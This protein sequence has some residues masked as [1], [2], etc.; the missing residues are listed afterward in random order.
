MNHF[1]AN[2]GNKLVTEHAQTSPLWNGSSSLYVFH[3]QIIHDLNVFN[4]LL[5]LLTHSNIHILNFDSKLLIIS[6]P[7][8]YTILICLFNASIL[9]SYVPRDWKRA[10]MTP[11]YKG[12]GSR[13]DPSNY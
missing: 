5:N 7:V 10:R 6:A 9:Q 1:F 13:S 2:V 4:H 3:F 8:N 11:V 12:K